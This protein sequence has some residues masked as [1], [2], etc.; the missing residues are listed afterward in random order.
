MAVLRMPIEQKDAQLRI[1]RNPRNGWLAISGEIDSWN[2]PAVRDALRAAHG[3]AG[4]LHLDV[5][6]LLFCDVSGI[7]AIVA[8]AAN[9]EGGRRLFLHGLDPQLQK[10]FTVVGWA[11]MPSLVIDA[12]AEDSV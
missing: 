6:R 8:T 2:V 1:S 9:L 4:D 3:K 12:H 10:V 7:R 11:G 5:S